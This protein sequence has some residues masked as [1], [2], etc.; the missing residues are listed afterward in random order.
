MD[1]WYSS[2]KFG[3]FS[4][5][6]ILYEEK[7]GNPDFNSPVISRHHCT[8][9]TLKGDGF[10]EKSLVI[11]IGTYSYTRNCD[12]KIKKKTLNMDVCHLRWL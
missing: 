8:G 4:R 10:E 2:W 1:I 12:S 9:H 7:S 11:Y 3:N 5:F 6:G